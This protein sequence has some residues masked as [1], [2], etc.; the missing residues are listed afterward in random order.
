MIDTTTQNISLLELKRRLGPADT[1]QIR[2]LLRVSPGQRLQT[3]LEMQAV[4]LNNWRQRL[5]RKHPHLNDLELCQ[6]V[7][8]RL[9]Q[10][11]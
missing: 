3:M 9:G 7:F 5:R 1:E 6:L 8:E 2:L 11:G 10:N 4:L